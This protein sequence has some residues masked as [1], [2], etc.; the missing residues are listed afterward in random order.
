MSHL[1]QELT[2]SPCPGVLNWRQFILHVRFTEFN[3]VFP[4]IGHSANVARIVLVEYTIGLVVES[5]FFIKELAKISQGF[6]K[7]ILNYGKCFSN[8]WQSFIKP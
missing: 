6:G 5:N 3:R 1:V 8:I 4:K 7:I 2:K